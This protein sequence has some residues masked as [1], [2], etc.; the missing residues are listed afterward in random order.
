M[1]MAANVSST[2]FTIPRGALA[3]AGRLI[4]TQWLFPFELQKNLI[5]V[6]TFAIIVQFID[7]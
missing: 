3:I 5:I 6:D 7:F 2:P 1:N 4:E